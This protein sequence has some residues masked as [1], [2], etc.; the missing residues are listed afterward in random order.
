MSV[1]SARR[2]RPLRLGAVAYDP[3]VITIWEGFKDWFA[4]QGLGFDYVLYSNYEAQAEAHLAGAIDV[5]WNSPLAWV[6]T[7]RLAS[8]E[9][10]VASAVAMRDTDQNLSSVILVRADGPV[11][12]VDA[13]RGR[14]VG[15]GAV[16]SP[17]ATLLPLALLASHG[18]D[19]ETD[20]TVRRFEI[21]VGKHGDHVGGERDA[22]RALLAGEVDAACVIDGNHLAFAREGT[23]PAGGVR[24]LAETPHYD[25]CCF[26]VLDDAPRA[27]VDHFVSLLLAMSYDDP[28]VRPLLEL[29]GLTQWRAGRTEGFGLLE[30]AVDRLGFY[31]ASGIVTAAGYSW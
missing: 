6:R 31:D 11:D 7:R 13:I 15:T 9:G 1:D 16:D 27:D 22:V 2:A 21:G 5:A 17:Q 18:L 26:T 19:P 8:A 25:H 10:R 28:V 4:T 30:A 3:K 14:T 20:F 24:V 23:I 29:E 12:S